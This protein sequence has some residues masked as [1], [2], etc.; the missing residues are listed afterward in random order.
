V[1]EPIQ[2]AAECFHPA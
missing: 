2:L 1:N